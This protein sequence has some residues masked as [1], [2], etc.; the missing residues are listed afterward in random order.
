M[1]ELT[2]KEHDLGINGTLYHG[3]WSKA[4]DGNI[5]FQKRDKRDFPAMYP[6]SLNIVFN[7][8]NAHGVPC[9][10]KVVFSPNCAYYDEAFGVWK[11]KTVR[12]YEESIAALKGAIAT[13]SSPHN[14]RVLNQRLVEMN[15][16]L[17]K[18]PA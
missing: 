10:P 6:S 12:S 4:E 1:R 3:L 9:P 13:S 14:I 16:R 8:V 5:E 2:F 7:N 18:L 11:S 17:S 15:E